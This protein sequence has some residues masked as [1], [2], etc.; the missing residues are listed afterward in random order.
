MPIFFQSAKKLSCTFVWF[1]ARSILNIQPISVCYISNE[2]NQIFDQI[3]N[4]YFWVGVRGAY[5]FWVMIERIYCRPTVTFC[6]H[7]WGL[8]A[9]SI[10]CIFKTL[11]VR[12]F[13]LCCWGANIVEKPHYYTSYMLLSYFEW[14]NRGWERIQVDSKQ[15]WHKMK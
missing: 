6:A 10:F 5:A 14:W 11:L 2:R 4:F 1:F 8:H 9:I 7:C 3:Y 12:T 13:M 15:T